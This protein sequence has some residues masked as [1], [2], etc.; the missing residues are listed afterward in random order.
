MKRSSADTPF[1]SQPEA[2]IY[3]IETATPHC[4]P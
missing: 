1:F 2:E 4:L 3:Q